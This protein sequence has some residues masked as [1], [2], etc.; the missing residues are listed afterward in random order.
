MVRESITKSLAL[1]ESQIIEAYQVKLR[2]Y[3]EEMSAQVLIKASEPEPESATYVRNYPASNPPEPNKTQV[4]NQR[5]DGTFPAVKVV[6]P[7]SDVQVPDSETLEQ[8]GKTGIFTS[9]KRLFSRM[10]SK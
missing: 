8:R 1:M 10:L 5:P 9:I 7:A 6:M 4:V 2:R 3:Q